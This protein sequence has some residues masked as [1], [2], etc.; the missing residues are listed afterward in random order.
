MRLVR[1]VTSLSSYL[2]SQSYLSYKTTS[3]P[4]MRV[5]ISGAGIAGNTLAYWLAK[6]GAR[7]TVVEKANSLLP[8]GQNVDLQGSAVTVVK[9][10]GLF[11]EIRRMHTT[12]Q[13]TQFIDPKGRP[14]GALLVKEGVTTSP[15]SEME[16]LRGD[17]AAI[18]YN[19]AKVH[20]NVEYSFGTTTK[21]V[22]SNED[23]AVKVE[24]SN[25]ETHDYDVLV[26]ADGQ[27]SKTRRQCFA[28]DSITVVD[29]GMYAVYF[30]IP[31]LESDNDL[32]NIYQALGS[33]IITTRP[34]PHG[35]IRALFTIMPSSDAQKTAW[36]GAIRSDHKTQQ[37]LVRREFADAGWQTQRLLD[38][39]DSAPDFYFQAMQQIKMSKWSTSRV[40]CIGDTA[41]AP[42]PLTGQGTSLAITG[43][44]ILAAE[45]SN[46]REGEHPS[47]AFEAYETAYRPQ[48]ESL[49]TIP[50]FVP[51]IAHYD[52]AW[53]RWVFQ[54]CISAFARI[55]AI[56]WVASRFVEDNEK[57][58]L[59]F[60]LPQY[61]DFDT[62][63]A[64]VH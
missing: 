53:R 10:M 21:Q 11:D 24:F 52:V 47:K 45:L 51:G 44:Y 46:L 40:I 57:N 15:S 23:D 49:Q 4:P 43:P 61:P 55:V 29:K 22:V 33:R 26:A 19:A 63:S 8:H 12:E 27:W 62:G 3:M 28:P 58:D 30:T 32:W 14:F 35:T 41:H 50:P 9:K 54:A 18:L 36:Q 59:G 38:A 25:G 39:M 7:I 6:T 42:T 37:E 56:P 48:V 1:Y 20:P 2:A 16:I 34:D 64:K 13:G 17:L 60:P 31:R 5:L